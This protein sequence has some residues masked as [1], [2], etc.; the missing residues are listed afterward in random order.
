MNYT[1]DEISRLLQGKRYSGE[2]DLLILQPDGTRACAGWEL[3]NGFHL[4]N[5]SNESPE[6]QLSDSELLKSAMK[7][8]RKGKRKI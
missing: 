7:E 2:E 1:N 8:L 3:R 5:L 4:S 6:K